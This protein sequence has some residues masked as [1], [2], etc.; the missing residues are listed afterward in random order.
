MKVAHSSK[1][2]DDGLS[3]PRLTATEAK[4]EFGQV[5]DRVIQGAKVVITRHDVPKAV[6]ISMDEF[7]TL[8]HAAQSKLDV[9]SGEFDAMLERMQTR[10]SRVAM[11]SAFH[12]S[13][14]K[15]GKAAVAAARKRG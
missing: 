7:N 2:P 13:P 15:L 5:L 14:R 8:S 12:A 1:G 11:Q 3:M 4:N 6:L 10:K 9:L